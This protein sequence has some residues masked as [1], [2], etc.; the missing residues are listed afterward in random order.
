MTFRMV[1]STDWHVADIGP[2][3]RI[4]DYTETCFDKINQIKRMCRKGKADICLIGGDVFHVKTSSK[5]RHA[6]VLRLMQTFQTFPCPVYSIVGNHDISHNNIG[7][8]GEKP[9]GVLF[10]SGALKMLDEETFTSKSGVKVRIIGHHFDPHV[11][12]SAF[13]HITK[14]D[15]DWLLLAYHGFASPQGVSYPGETTFKYSDLAPLPVDDWYFGHWHVDQSVQVVDGK[16]FVNI[17]SLTRGSLSVG[18]ISRSPKA[19]F[20]TYEK[21]SRKLVQVKLKVKPAAEVFDMRK[22]DR[23]D[24]EQ[25]KINEFIENLRASTEDD[26][27]ATEDDIA[28]KLDTYGMG[29][30]VRDRVNDLLQKAEQELSSARGA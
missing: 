3:N 22:K 27:G 8:L 30:D 14:G 7:T 13:D 20:C 29:A 4:D 9:L 5:V 18:N 26:E 11:K 1:W 12:L 16:N 21:G 19:V 25:E 10:V 15:E 17:G 6:L 2:E 28:N 24:R 23:K